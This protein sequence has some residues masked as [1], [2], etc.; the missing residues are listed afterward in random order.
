M[1]FVII[2]VHGAAL[3]IIAEQKAFSSINIAWIVLVQLIFLMYTALLQAFN[4]WIKM[5]FTFTSNIRI[6]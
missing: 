4:R 6:Y 3:N 2:T 1:S 5:E